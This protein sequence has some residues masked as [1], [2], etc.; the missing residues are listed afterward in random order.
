MKKQGMYIGGSSIPNLPPGM[1]NEA[2]H[3]SGQVAPAVLKGLKDSVLHDGLGSY[4]GK[5]TLKPLPKALANIAGS[6]FMLVPGFISTPLAV[7]NVF[8]NISKHFK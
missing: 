8:K 6:A 3:V 5:A 4:A 7:L 2:V 1:M